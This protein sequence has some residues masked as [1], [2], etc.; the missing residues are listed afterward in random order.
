MHRPARHTAL[1]NGQGGGQRSVR[2]L[3][4]M[5]TVQI[6]YDLELKY[7]LTVGDALSAVFECSLLVHSGR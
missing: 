2:A 3:D 7:V 6:G 5:Q 1:A 4:P